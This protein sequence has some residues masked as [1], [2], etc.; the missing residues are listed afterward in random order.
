MADGEAR[1]ERIDRAAAARRPKSRIGAAN[2][3]R[4]LDAAL[5]A[6]ASH[7]LRGTRIEHIAAT[8]GMSKTNLLYYFRSK[9]D[10]YKAVLTRTLDLWLQPLRAL[11]AA[12][13]PQAALSAYI[14]EKLDASRRYPDASRLF[15]IEIMQGAPHLGPVLE[16]ELA[17]LV[18]A[19]I[20]I[21][22]GWISAGTDEASR[23]A[24]SHLHDLGDHAALC[25]FRDADPRA[26]RQRPR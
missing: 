22:E 17:D 16:T 24:P 26:D 15:A 14:G 25:R 12:S 6:F 13:G 20:V 5:V 23:P 18:G 10:L 2:V 11:D 8:A 3:D 21:I 1:G 9:D 19:K 4:I 7:G